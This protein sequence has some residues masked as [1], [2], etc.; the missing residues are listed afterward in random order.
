M[1]KLKMDLKIKFLGSLK[2]TQILGI[3]T[4][5]LIL[6]IIFSLIIIPV[7]VEQKAKKTFPQ[8]KPPTTPPGYG[9][10]GPTSP[11]PLK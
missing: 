3:L 6:A 7:T 1:I 11:P 9:M 4:L 8:I 2:K 10:K 5:I